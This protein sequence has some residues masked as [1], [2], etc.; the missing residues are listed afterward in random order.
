[1]IKFCYSGFRAGRP[2]SNTLRSL[3]QFNL[4]NPT[5]SNMVLIS[6]LIFFARSFTLAYLFHS[7]SSRG[8]ALHFLWWARWWRSSDLGKE[9]EAG[10]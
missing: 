8:G 2:P 6:F 1:M 9:E 5:I 4:W 10:G 3:S 7:L